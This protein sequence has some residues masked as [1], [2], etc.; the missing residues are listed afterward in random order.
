MSISESAI[1][2]TTRALEADI[3]ATLGPDRLTLEP[4]VTNGRAFINDAAEFAQ[5]L[6]DDVQQYFH[7]TFV[8]TTWPACPRHPHHPLW[9]V[10][11][12]WCCGGDPLARLGELSSLRHRPP[13]VSSIDLPTGVRLDYVAQGH[14][15]G[16]PVVML[17]GFTDSLKSFGMVMPHLPASIRAYAVT[18]RGHGDSGRPSR[19]YRAH[20][21]AADVAAFLDAMGHDRAVLVGHSMGATNALRFAIDYPHRIMGL[22]IAATFAS[23]RANP[24]A[25]DFGENGVA[26]LED[27]IDQAF[28]REFQESTLAQPI[29]AP[30]LDAA[31]QESLKVPARVWRAAFEGFLEDDVARDLGVITAP[32]LIVWGDRDS[33]C[34]REDQDAL[35]AALPHARLVVYENAG[36]AL[37]WEEPERFAT[38]VERF[39]VLLK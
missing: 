21:F 19:G 3:T 34:R 29:P 39:A 9:F 8:D 14:P 35:R 6:V 23:Y 10:N 11:G 16:V 1:D 28:V 25:L 24:A 18:Q 12:W 31:I 17:H 5:G 26:K 27:P 15:D 32:T 37:H 20:D 33:F 2:R 36:H 4:F 13:D 7:D 38:E 30:F 22:L